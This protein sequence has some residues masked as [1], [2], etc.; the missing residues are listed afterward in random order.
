MIFILKR[1]IQSNALEDR[2]V[3]DKQSWDAAINFMESM[4]KDKL[5]NSIYTW[6]YLIRKSFFRKID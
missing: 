4:I 2:S 1:V 5:K 3:P 6:F